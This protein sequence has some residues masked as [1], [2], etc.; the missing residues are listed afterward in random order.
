M[1]ELTETLTVSLKPVL[2][3]TVYK[4]DDRKEYY[5]ESHD[6]NDNG[7]FGAGKPLQ[8]ETL[9]GIVDVFF[10]DRKNMSAITGL[11]P[12][13]LLDYKVRPGGNYKMVWYNPAQVRV[14]HH[15]APL[16]LTTAKCWVPALLYIVE[17]RELTVYALNTDKRPEEKTVLYMA[18]FFNVSDDGD[19]CLGNA[20]VQKP[21]EKTFASIIK[22]W[23]DLFWLSEFS[24]V[25]GS[26]K[27]KS[28]DLHGIWK[29][30]LA[31]KT[32]LKWADTGELLKLKKTLAQIL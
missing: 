30:L 15:A 24:H 13:N 22:Y 12:V 14:I 21:K 11:I 9:Q 6:I 20:K 18:P 1:N 26:N 31:S 5:L 19:V 29:K 8:Q 3:V 27:V 17:N 10:D 4:S 23:E 7:H 32:K 28:N 16:K 2:A 25:N